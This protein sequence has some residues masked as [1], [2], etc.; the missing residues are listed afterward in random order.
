MSLVPDIFAR[1]HLFSKEQGG[2]TQPIPPIQFGCPL[3]FQDEGFD[4][5][6]LLDQIGN[7][8]LLGETMI[9]PIKFLNSNNILPRMKVGDQFLLWEGKYI[10]EGEVIE[11]VHRSR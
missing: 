11:I 5:R 2:R 9:V 7:P 4:C 6:L 10:A 8:L 1:I 3:F